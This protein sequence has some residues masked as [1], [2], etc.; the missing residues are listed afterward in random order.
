M[1]AYTYLA[2]KHSNGYVRRTVKEN[3]IL[4]TVMRLSEKLSRE[5]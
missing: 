1:L 4:D 3:N 5:R 2:T